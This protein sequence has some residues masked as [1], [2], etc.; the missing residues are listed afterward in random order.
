MTWSNP[1]S[2]SHN[3]IPTSCPRCNSPWTNYNANIESTNRVLQCS[4]CPKISQ[5]GVFNLPWATLTTN[6][7]TIRT[8]IYNIFFDWEDQ[9]SDLYKESFPV[10]LNQN[11]NII[12]LLHLSNDQINVEINTLIIFS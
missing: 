12:K 9:R 1:S 3:L 2:S 8:E 7:I 5:G 4:L 6:Y 11:I 10:L